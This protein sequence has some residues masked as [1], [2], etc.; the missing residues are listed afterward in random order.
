MLEFGYFQV[1]FH[2]SGN[3]LISGS[4]DG[5]LKIFDLL[6]ARPI[7]DLLGHKD[8]VSAVKFSTKGD[9]FASAGQDK[10]VYV[11]KT[12][13]DEVD[14]KLGISNDNKAKSKGMRYSVDGQ[15][16][17]EPQTPT[18]LSSS[19]AHHNNRENIENLEPALSKMQ[20]SPDML[21]EIYKKTDII[22]Q[23]MVLMEKRL[24]LLEDQIKLKNGD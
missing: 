19:K 9:F 13:F 18:P 11:W 6:E 20:I 14:E 3:Y 10:V 4:E 17:P 21:E 1:S 8:A 24:T 15:P 12:N 7:Y 2:S 23:T 16:E 22:M 5:S